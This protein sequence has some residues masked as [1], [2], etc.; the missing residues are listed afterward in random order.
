MKKMNIWKRLGLL[1]LSTCAAIT[2]AMPLTASAAGQAA[3]YADGTYTGT[4]S[5]FGGDIKVKVTVKGGKIASI[6]EVS[7]SETP[8]YYNKAKTLYKSIA[9]K[10]S[11][12]VDSV[13][14]ATRSSA[15]IKEAVRKALKKAAKADPSKPDASIFASGKGT[16]SSPFQIKTARQLRAFGKSVAGEVDYTGYYV[17][18]SKNI[19]VSSKEWSPIGGGSTAFNGTF[20]GK[21]HT[22]SG[23]T[24]R[25]TNKSFRSGKASKAGFFSMLGGKAVVKGL[26]LTKV[27]LNI[28]APGIVDAG[29]ITGT[30]TGQGDK[31]HSGST[32]RNCS[33][34]SKERGRQY[35]GGR[36]GRHAVPRRGH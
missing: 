22:V 13:S 25:P 23:M 26:K 31:D 3:S 36:P 4:G 11:T 8:E 34:H 5:G 35:L 10:N 14:G 27:N 16:K 12:D 24:I 20:L 2:L 6:K 33:A 17:Q 19:S 9:E 7:Q 29:T 21:G 28:K 32:I 18:L 1:T 15:G 30:T